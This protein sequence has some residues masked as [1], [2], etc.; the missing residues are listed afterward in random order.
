MKERNKVNRG[1][2]DKFVEGYKQYK[3]LKK[4]QA[5]AKAVKGTKEADK[6]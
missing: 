2:F 6:K 3:A 4:A 1:S 5:N